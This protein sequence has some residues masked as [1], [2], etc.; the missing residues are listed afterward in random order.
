ML[1]CVDRVSAMDWSTAASISN[2]MAEVGLQALQDISNIQ[3]FDDD[4]D[5][6]EHSKYG[7]CVDRKL[8]EF[9][10]NELKPLEIVKLSQIIVELNNII[11]RLNQVTIQEK[12]NKF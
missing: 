3:N 5:D 6:G 8:K 10:L 2:A 1:Q 7:L 12:V 11:F 4:D 9:E